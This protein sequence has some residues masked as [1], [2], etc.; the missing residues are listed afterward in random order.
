MFPADLA[1]SASSAPVIVDGRPVFR[2]ADTIATKSAA[3]RAII[4]GDSLQQFADQAIAP[5]IRIE[6]PIPNG[7]ATV[8]LKAPPD[9]SPDESSDLQTSFTVTKEDA[10]GTP[11]PA[12]QAE[13]WAAELRQRFTQAK[14]QRQ[15]GY[16]QQNIWKLIAVPITAAIA[17]WLSGIFWRAYLFKAVRSVTS[18]SD[19]PERLDKKASPFTAAN[20]FLNTTLL[21]LRIGIWTSAILYI[22]NLF[23]RARQQSHQIVSQLTSTFTRGTVPLGNNPLSILDI[24]KV[25]LLVLLV[26]LFS[27]II[28][29]AIK[30]RV[31]HE[32]G[33]N[34]GVQEAVAILLRY[35]LIFVGTLIVLQASGINLSSLTIL[36]SALGVGAGLGLQNIVKDVGSGLVLVFER[37]IQVGEFVQI[38]GQ[39]GTVERIGAR[40]AEIRTLDQ[41]SIIVP[42]SQFL[43][44]EVI[45]WSHRNP[46]SRIRIPI[47]VSYR[48]NPEQVRKVLLETGSAHGDVLGSPPP[49]VLFA[50]LGDSAFEFEL[51]VWISQPSRQFIIK[52]DLLFTITKAFRQHNIEIPYPQRDLHIVSGMLPVHS[53]N[54]S[55]QDIKKAAE[56]SDSAS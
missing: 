25:L 48:S 18:D 1:T 22:T 11:S 42:N 20:L 41:I 28:A 50:R 21:L 38:G 29:N 9:E 17:Y 46:I 54:H 23:P 14:I 19:H 56:Q 53:E 4:I 13:I 36:A 27:Q 35:S 30:R 40:S 7:L 44:N 10:A 5:D 15:D 8:W 47:G 2:V 52:S 3:A 12:A 37:P 31:L 16:L 33:I 49:Q 45:N 43:E 32:T 6:E 26:F 55:D 34:R 51:L 24:F 39:T